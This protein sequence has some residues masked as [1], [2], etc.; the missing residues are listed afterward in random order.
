MKLL[1]PALILAYACST[2]S[3]QNTI[4]ANPDQPYCT[5]WK[6]IESNANKK[7]TVEG[8]FRKYTPEKAGKGAGH[9]FWDW[10]I[11]LADSTAIP[12]I[13]K[14]RSLD[15]AAF[16]N[17]K[18]VVDAL[19]FEGIIIGTDD[20]PYAQSARGFRLDVETIKNK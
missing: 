7:A 3:T 15:L 5:E 11:M 2:G 19:V 20:P 13:A 12:V 17:R 4:P 9:M 18:V 6:C 10:E 1:L 8:L 16:E 14:N